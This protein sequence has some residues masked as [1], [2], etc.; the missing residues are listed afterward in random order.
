MN[1]TMCTSI[2]VLFQR[3]QE[4]VKAISEMG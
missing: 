4:L 2:Q 3:L 1:G